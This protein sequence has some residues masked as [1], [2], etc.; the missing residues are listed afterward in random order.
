MGM[1]RI[2]EAKG[3][4][5]T[6]ENGWT[7][8]VQFGAGNYGDNY[9][10]W[11]IPAAQRPPGDM[12]SSLAETA[13]WDTNNKWLLDEEGQEV[14]GYQTPAQVLALMNRV[15]ALAPAP[16]APSTSDGEG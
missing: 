7:V 4:H 1:F 15:A 2:T 13:A 8:S 6:F 12:A 9:R 5:V 16:P 11:M 14:Q 10:L 3:F